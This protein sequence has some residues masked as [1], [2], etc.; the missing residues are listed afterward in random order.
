MRFT[1]NARK[2]RA[3]GFTSFTTIPLGRTKRTRASGEVV[4]MSE[5]DRLTE[6][7]T[8]W[9]LIRTAHAPGAD[10]EAVANEA[11]V[12]MER[13]IG[14]YHDAVGR[15]LKVKLRDEHLADEVSQEFWTKL[16]SR[17]LA[18]AD[19]EKGRF[20]DYLRTILQRLII[21]H[22]RGRKSLPLPPGDLTDANATDADFDQVWRDS[23]IKR[24]WAR[25]E[26]YELA[27]PKNRYSTVLQLRVA[28]PDAPIEAIA[29]LLGIHV[30]AEVRPDAFRKSLQRARSKFLELLIQ[31][32][33]DTIHPAEPEDIK[34]EIYELGLGPLYRRYSDDY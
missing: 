6:I 25:L 17:K 18:G 20:R 19:P 32:L 21:D 33:R 13:L 29:E 2:C 27:T 24:V 8:E 22:F 14:R 9:T 12:A 11:A 5:K 30:G 34:A 23:V 3:G 16:L 31:E 10:G 15:Y 1:W 7:P 4:R 26:N 28:H